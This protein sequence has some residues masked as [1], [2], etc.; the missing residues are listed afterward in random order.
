VR[1]A[2]HVRSA[3]GTGCFGGWG[4]SGLEFRNVRVMA[5]HCDG[6]AGRGAPSSGALVFAGGNEGGANSSGLRITNATYYQLC[7]HNLVWPGTAFVETELKD[8]PFVPR[9]P[10]RLAFCWSTN[11]A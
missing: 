4:V 3:F 11:Y 6:W 8:A 2:F 10:L 5:T 1:A 7:K 9:A